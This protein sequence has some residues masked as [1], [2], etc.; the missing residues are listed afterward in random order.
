MAARVYG[1]AAR[2]PTRRALGATIR[3]LRQERRLSLETLAG[4]AG[5]HTTYLSGIERGI[6]NPSWDKLG[7]LAVALD[8][9]VSEIVLRAERG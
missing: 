7:A 9:A 5:M 6:N 4:A 3:T 2:P 8:V 1:V